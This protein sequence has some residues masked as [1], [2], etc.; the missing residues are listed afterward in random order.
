MRF[1]LRVPDEQ[2][3]PA[4]GV[5]GQARRGIVLPHGKQELKL[6]F[7]STAVQ[8]YD[9][10][11]LVDVEAV[12]DSLLSLP[13]TAECIVPAIQPSTAEIDY[14]DAFIGYTYEQT[15]AIKNPSHLPAKCEVVEQSADAQGDRR[16]RVSPE[17][18]GRDPGQGLDRRQGQVHRR[19]PRPDVPADVRAHRRPRSSP[20]SPSS[21]TRPP[22][23]PTCILSAPKIDWG[24]THGADRL[25]ARA[26][27]H[28][29]LAH[30]RGLQV[31][32]AQGRLALLRPAPKRHARAGR[33]ARARSLAHCDDAVKSTNDLILQIVHAPEAVVPLSVVGVGATITANAA[34]RRARP[35]RELLVARASATR[36]SLENLGRKPQQLTWANTRGAAAAQGERAPRARTPPK[37]PPAPI[38]SITPDKVL[39]EPGATC[40]FTIKGV[41]EAGVKPRCSSARAQQGQRQGLPHLRAGRLGDLHRPADRAVG[42]ARRVRLYTYAEGDVD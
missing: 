22:S 42:R 15:I 7:I 20:R 35:R 6:N 1:R 34:A 23:A 9:L 10:A 29:R 16:V 36:S 38:F 37:A 3:R 2:R 8:K 32:A 31:P 18:R 26:H 30:R 40:T 13:I 24:K 11:M 39:M 14:G 25:D 4:R 27:A 19:P 5:R 12:G 17:P 28:Q 21:S 33:G 41:A